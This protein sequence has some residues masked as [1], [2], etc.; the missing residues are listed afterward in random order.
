MIE[1]IVH[2]SVDRVMDRLT[3]LRY[4]FDRTAVTQRP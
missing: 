4:I 3:T 1:T 2:S